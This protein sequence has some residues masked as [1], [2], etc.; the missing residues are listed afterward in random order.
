MSHFFNI[1]STAIYCQHALAK[2]QLL[3]LLLFFKTL[4]KKNNVIVIGL[5]IFLSGPPKQKKKMY[6]YYS[7]S[8]WVLF[9][10]RFQE[11]QWHLLP[12]TK[13]LALFDRV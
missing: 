9:M 13:L 12:S 4:Q 5:L 2:S 7:H 8:R 1:S 6:Y 10:I 3:L 11:M